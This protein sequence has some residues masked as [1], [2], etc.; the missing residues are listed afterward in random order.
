MEAHFSTTPI[1]DVRVD[2]F[3]SDWIRQHYHGP[4]H[5]PSQYVAD[6]RELLRGTVTVPRSCRT[7]QVRHRRY[8]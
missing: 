4:A 6:R 3:L 8:R 5:L 1:Q 7:L 2:A